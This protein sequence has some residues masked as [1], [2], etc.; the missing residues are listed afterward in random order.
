MGSLCHVVPSET[1]APRVARERSGSE[2]HNG[3]GE[4][5]GFVVHTATEVA[6][7]GIHCGKEAEE[8]NTEDNLLHR[9]TINLK[10]K[11]VSYF[12][13]HMYYTHAMGVV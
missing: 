2:Q 6:V 13:V 9:G 7:T 4:G 5:R 1:G 12:C 3:S 8:A 11:F 10:E